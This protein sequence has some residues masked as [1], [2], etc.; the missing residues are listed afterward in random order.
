MS[1]E[2]AIKQKM[3]REAKGIPLKQY[4]EEDDE[5]TKNQ[6]DDDEDDFD[7]FDYSILADPNANVYQQQQ[8]QQQQPPHVNGTES[9]R[10]SDEGMFED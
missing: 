8:Q 7:D 4:D 3:Q 9:S 6:E 10:L 2:D 5:N 1:Y